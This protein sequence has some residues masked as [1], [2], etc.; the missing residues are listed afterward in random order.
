MVSRF[1]TH[2]Q[3]WCLAVSGASKFTGNYVTAN[4]LSVKTVTLHLNWMQ[5]T[6]Q[7]TSSKNKFQEYSDIDISYILC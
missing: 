4:I 1:L 5:T 3:L 7:K 2:T 6:I